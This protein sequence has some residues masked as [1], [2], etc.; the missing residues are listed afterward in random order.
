MKNILNEVD[1][2]EITNRIQN[3]S[4]TNTRL[5]GNMDMQQMLPHCTTQLKLALG[6]ISQQQQGPSLMRSKLG[7]WLLS[8]TIPW[9]KGAATPTEMNAEIASFSLTDIEKKKRTIGLPGKGKAA[10]PFKGASFFW[11]A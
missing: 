1:Y 6:E 5:W 3:L 10:N 7:K 11:R 4:E 9:P 8:S 2:L